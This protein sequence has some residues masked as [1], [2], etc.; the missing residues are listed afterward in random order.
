[1]PIAYSLDQISTANPTA[2]N[3]DMHA[4]KIINLANGTNPADAVNYS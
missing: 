2:G 4:F 1:M 3:V